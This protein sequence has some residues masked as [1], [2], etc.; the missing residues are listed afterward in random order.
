VYNYTQHFI[1]LKDVTYHST[2]V[3]AHSYDRKNFKSLIKK[4]LS[5]GIFFFQ[6]SKRRGLSSVAHAF[7]PSTREAEAG[8]FEFEASLVCRVSS[9]TARTIQRNPVS[10]N[11]TKQEEGYHSK[12]HI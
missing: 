10:K 11:K 6:S 12:I 5:L 2:I 3:Y 7:N 8:G 9:R 4:V 1:I